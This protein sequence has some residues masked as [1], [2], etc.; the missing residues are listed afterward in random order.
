MAMGGSTRRPGKIISARCWVGLLLCAGLQVALGVSACEASSRRF[1]CSAPSTAA[2]Q[3]TAVARSRAHGMVLVIQ[4]PQPLSREQPLCRC[5][6]RRSSVHVVRMLQNNK[7]C[8]CS[9]RLST[10]PQ[11]LQLRGGA[12]GGNATVAENDNAAKYDRTLW[13]MLQDHPDEIHFL[14]TVFNFLQVL[15]LSQSIHHHRFGAPG[16]LFAL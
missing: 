9:L 6:K 12:S 7:D 16:C 5:S 10:C 11:V 2:G 4:P 1:P 14:N 8:A 15:A 3:H 13:D